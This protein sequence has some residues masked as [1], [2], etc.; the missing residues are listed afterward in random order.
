MARRIK[1]MNPT[2]E[3]LEKGYTNSPKDIVIQEIN[4]DT[5]KFVELTYSKDGKVVKLV[6]GKVIRLR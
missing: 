1:L 3:L 5:L 2:K 4:V 6:E